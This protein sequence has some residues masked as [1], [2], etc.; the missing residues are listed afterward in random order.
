MGIII[1][2]KMICCDTLENI[3]QGRSLEDVF[4]DIYKEEVGEVE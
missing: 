2:G 3:T 4:F 1:I